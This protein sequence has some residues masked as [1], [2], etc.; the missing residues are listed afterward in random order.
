MRKL[1][2]LLVL[3][4]AAAA[5]FAQQSLLLL[6]KKDRTIKTWSTGSYIE[7]TMNNG[8]EVSGTFLRTKTKDSIVVRTFQVQRLESSKGFVFFDT[9]HTGTYVIGLNEIRNGRLPGNKKFAYKASEYTAYT[10]AVVFATMAIVNGVKFDDKFSTSLKQAGIRGGGL[11]LLGRVF[12]WL[13]KDDYKMGSKY[14]MVV[15]DLN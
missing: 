9:L 7:F 14:K 15:I 11:F 5:C 13:G 12:H 6:K 8:A 10:A 1:T 4:F 2:A 3:L